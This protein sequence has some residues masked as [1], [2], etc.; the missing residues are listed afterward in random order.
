MAKRKQSKATARHKPTLPK[1]AKSA[2][3][4]IGRLADNPALAADKVADRLFPKRLD[5]EKDAPVDA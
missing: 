4:L 1:P 5:V 3:A 2:P